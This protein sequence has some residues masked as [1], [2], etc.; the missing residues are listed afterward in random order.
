MALA[1]AAL[2]LGGLLIPLARQAKGQPETVTLN[3]TGS[4]QTWTVPPGVTDATVTLNGASGGSGAV[5]MATG[6]PGGSAIGSIPVTPG[7]TLQINVGC[8]G[9]NAAGVS[10]GTGGFGGGGN[11][12]NGGIST[13]TGPGG[14]PPLLGNGTG[15]GGGRW[16]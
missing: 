15:G 7:E 13:F 12:G 9:Q 1:V 6:A 3:C 5:P 2:A 14:G 8:R 10:G 16:R 4:A 11:G